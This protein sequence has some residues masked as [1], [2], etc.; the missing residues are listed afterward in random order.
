MGKQDERVFAV[1]RDFSSPNIIFRE[2]IL[3]RK[4][5]KTGFPKNQ[6]NTRFL[7]TGG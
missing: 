1:R 3:N 7:K 2:L 5:S 4:F 6:P